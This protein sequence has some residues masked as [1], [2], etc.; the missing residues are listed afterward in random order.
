[1]CIARLYTHMEPNKAHRAADMINKLFIAHVQDEPADIDLNDVMAVRD[2]IREL[3]HELEENHEFKVGNFGVDKKGPTPSKEKNT[4]KIVEL[5]KQR[6]DEYE[7]DEGEL[8]SEYSGNKFYPDDDLVVG[9]KYIHLSGNKT[10]YL[11]ESRIL[12]D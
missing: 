10:Y 11:P 3:A 6:A 8:V 1:M 12:K 2:D 7:T 5:T 9:V 4:V